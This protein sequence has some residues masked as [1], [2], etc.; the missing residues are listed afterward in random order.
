MQLSEYQKQILSDPKTLRE[1]LEIYLQTPEKVEI[2]ASA[3]E[4]FL[5]P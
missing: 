4:N 2:Y 3:C 5:D 1:K